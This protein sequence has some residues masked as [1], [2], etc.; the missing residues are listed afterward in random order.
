MHPNLD[1][2]VLTYILV[3]LILL[4]LI[5]SMKTKFS[6]VFK[7]M[8]KCF[9]GGAFIYIFN[10]FGKIIDFTIPFNAITSSIAG[11]F[12]IPGV[13]LIFIIKYLIYP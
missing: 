11:I 10:F 2:N 8:I 9:L 3:V 5:I 6:I 7:L 12:E 4:S 1:Y 13:I